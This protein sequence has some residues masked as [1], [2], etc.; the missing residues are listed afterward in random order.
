MKRGRVTGLL[1][2]LLLAA[3]SVSW[4]AIESFE[5]DSPEQ[6]ARFKQLSGEL[7]CL[8]CQNQ[9]IGDSNADLAQDLRREVYQMIKAGQSDAEIVDF[10]VARYG[11]F[12]LYRPPVTTT[13]ALLWAGPFLLIA[14]GLF[15]LLRFIRT[16]VAT[17]AAGD[18]AL[19]AE[20]QARLDALL[21]NPAKD[22][23]P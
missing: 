1:L 4:A 22:Q 3:A 6:E 20:E 21:Q 7:R 15:F 11:D 13:T 18:G 17:T 9:S 2:S 8:V 12:V 5:F 14:I 19:S 10:L 23:R 16:R